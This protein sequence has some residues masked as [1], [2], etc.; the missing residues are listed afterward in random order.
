MT[1]TGSRMEIIQS[2]LGLVEC[3]AASKNR[4]NPPT[5]KTIPEDNI[6]TSLIAYS[7]SVNTGQSWSEI[8]G[9]EIYNDISIPKIISAD[10]E[11]GFI[12]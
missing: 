7:T 1:T 11:K 5:I 2:P 3:E 8:L 9:L 6:L 10:E 12:R 4:V